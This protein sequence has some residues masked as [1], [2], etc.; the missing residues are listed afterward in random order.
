MYIN[1]Q[2]CHATDL[3]LIRIPFQWIITLSLLLP[4][5]ILLT[6]CLEKS[7]HYTSSATSKTRI[8]LTNRFHVAV[9]L[10]SNRSV[11]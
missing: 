10:F 8:Y 3:D 11:K 6:Y 1:F 5:N 9:R 7:F 2:R 4:G